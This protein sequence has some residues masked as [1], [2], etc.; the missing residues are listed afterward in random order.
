[1]KTHGLIVADNGSDIHIQGA[2]DERWNSDVLSP[3]FLSLQASDFEVI[4]LGWNPV[5]SSVPSGD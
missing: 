1:M 2:M 5:A 3:A 4:E